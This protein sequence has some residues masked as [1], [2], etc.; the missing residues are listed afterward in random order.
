L[1]RASKTGKVKKAIRKTAPSKKIQVDDDTIGT[2]G[3]IGI[4]GTAVL[5]AGYLFA[6]SGDVSFENESAVW[7]TLS[8]HSQAQLA[9]LRRH[10]L[11]G[12][13]L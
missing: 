7:N 8:T 10:Y 6:G 12:H 9:E 11:P 13:Y 1:Y 3:S 5:T 2:L 4:F